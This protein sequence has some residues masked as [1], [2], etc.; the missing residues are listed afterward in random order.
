[1]LHSL[2]TELMLSVMR[3]N[4]A[5]NGFAIIIAFLFC[6]LLRLNVAEEIDGENRSADVDL[7]RDDVHPIL[8]GKLNRYVLANLL[9]GKRD[10]KALRVSNRFGKRKDGQA[11]RMSNRFGKRGDDKSGQTPQALRM[12][13]RFGRS[14]TLR[15]SNR[16]GKRM[17]E[18]VETIGNNG[19]LDNINN[20]PSPSNTLHSQDSAYHYFFNDKPTTSG[21]LMYLPEA[22]D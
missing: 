6:L 2:V 1:M 21:L 18:T 3:S 15:M 9:S 11:L 19:Q 10:G 5:G 17:M 13:N 22:S 14:G 7:F 8:S 4:V 20:Y 16:F 12:S